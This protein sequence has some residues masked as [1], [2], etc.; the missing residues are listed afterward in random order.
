MTPKPTTAD[1]MWTA[2]TK[3]AKTTPETTS[4][5][6]SE[7]G[8]VVAEHLAH[9]PAY[10]AQRAPFLQRLAQDREQVVSAASALA[11]LLEALIDQLGVAVSL[12]RLQALH[13]VVLGLGI[14]PE[15]V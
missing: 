8:A 12:E 2:S 7:G 1:R 6:G 13:L 15:D 11:H 5:G 3:S 9:R 14:H 10:L 4:M